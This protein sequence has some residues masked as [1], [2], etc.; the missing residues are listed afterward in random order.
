MKILS[1]LA[2]IVTVMIPPFAL[3]TSSPLRKRRTYLADD[4]RIHYEGR[5]DF[6]AQ[7]G[8]GINIAQADWG[9][10]AVHFQVAAFHDS[11]RVFSVSLMSIFSRI[12]VKVTR[13]DG[14]VV[15]EDIIDQFGPVDYQIRL[16]TKGK[17][18]VSFRKLT[19]PAPF[20]YGIGLEL[21]GSS[22]VQLINVSTRRGVRLM[23]YKPQTTRRI[24]FIGASDMAGFC[25]DGTP[26]TPSDVA[27]QASFM[28]TNCDEALPGLISEEFNA[29]T[30]VQA[31]SGIGV[32]QNALGSVNASLLGPFQMPELFP[33][34]ISVQEEPV[35]DSSLFEP[36]LVVISLGGN[37]FNNNPFPPEVSTFIDAYENFLLQVLDSFPENPP[38][39]VSICGQGSPED[40]LNPFN[41]RCGPCP[42]VEEAALA[43]QTKYPD[44]NTH[45]IFVT[46]DGSIVTGVDDIGC[47]SHKNALGQSRVA[48]FLVPQLKDIMGW[49]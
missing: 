44:T 31:E 46:C 39:I 43:F 24:Q 5:W 15:H 27:T 42:F 37:D 22:R 36:D 26:D 30:S 48:E 17:Y 23:Q 29:E 35:Y 20:G 38:T 18:M 14:K 33:R 7:E 9:C 45:Y 8:T 34:T 32:F 49:E 1:I 21:A 10:T 41:N 40:L 28:V 25:V 11:S 47:E 19:Q 2:L 3:S 4:R 16:K 13:F 12:S 6:I